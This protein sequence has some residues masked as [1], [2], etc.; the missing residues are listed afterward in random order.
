[1]ESKL[2]TLFDYVK[3]L[4]E[5]DIDRIIE[6]VLGIFAASQLADERPD[7]PHCDSH[8]IIKFGNRK[9]K[10][11]K[12]Q[13]FMCKDCGRTFMHTTNTLLQHSH[14]ERS[15][16]VDFIKDTICGISLDRSAEKYHFS[17]QTAFTMRH[18]VLMALEDWLNENPVTL[19]R[20]V[21]LDETFV[22]ESFKGTKIPE[23]AGRKAR[24][25][26]AKSQKRGI[27]NEYIAIC[28]GIQRDGNAIAK[29][30][31][32]A[33]P[34]SLE[35]HSIYDGHIAE[36]TLLLSDGLR[37][38][39]ILKL[40]PGCTLKDVNQEEPDGMMNLNTV[41]SMHSYIKKSYGHYR[42]VATK[43][44][45]RYNALFS[46]AFRCGKDFVESLF[47]SLSKTSTVSYWHSTQDVR[48]YGL[49]CL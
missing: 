44:L 33:K 24:K 34:S 6:F 11:I 17:H 14:Y 48:S 22:L 32:R 7:C 4:C 39:N 37:S 23:S 13:R 38:Y 43:Y 15:I 19:S 26:G 21:E 27:T 18:K 10:D 40:F 36:N 35:I 41:N 31:S 46:V 9:Y 28:T 20:I 16:W 29:S 8:A 30:V 49:L 47:A 1:M 45:N 25:H 5:S 12:K 42:G 3:S 2:N